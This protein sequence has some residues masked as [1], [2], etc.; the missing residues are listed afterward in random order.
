MK[1]VSTGC[2]LLLSANLLALL[3]ET[4]GATAVMLVKLGDTV[5]IYFGKDVTMI[6]TAEILVNDS[7][8]TN[9]ARKKFGN[10]IE[11][12]NGKMTIMNIKSID[13]S[14]FLYNLHD[15][16]MAISLEEK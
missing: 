7:K 2:M 13:L 1:I 5:D 6:K 8:L 12:R 14:T 3:Q 10:R 15:K 16:P 9:F 4:N 11:W